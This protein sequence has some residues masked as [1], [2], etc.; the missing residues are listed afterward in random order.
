MTSSRGGDSENTQAP[1][2]LACPL[3]QPY[4]ICLEG[5]STTGWSAYMESM[6]AQSVSYL[7]PH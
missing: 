6:A 2:S 4:G 1:G 5:T 3:C 7:P